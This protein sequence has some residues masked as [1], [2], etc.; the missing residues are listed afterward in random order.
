MDKMTS[1]PSCDHDP[2]YSNVFVSSHPQQR[3]FICRLCGHEGYAKVAPPVDD[4]GASYEQLKDKKQA[5]G[6]RGPR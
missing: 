2:V 4:E 1:E 3:P 5:G 6:F